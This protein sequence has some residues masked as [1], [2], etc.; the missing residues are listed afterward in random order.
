M[1]FK[2]GTICVERM[3]QGKVEW[4]PLLNQREYE[5][6]VGCFSLV[7]PYAPDN[8]LSAHAVSKHSISYQPLSNT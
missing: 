8:I 2:R 7:V 1:R 4:L 5:E 6:W 3:V